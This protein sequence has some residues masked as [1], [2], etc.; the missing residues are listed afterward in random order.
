MCAVVILAVFVLSQE[1]VGATKRSVVGSIGSSAFSIG[2]ALLAAIATTTDNWR[3]LTLMV[4]VA[5]VPCA[6]LLLLLPESPRWLAS[7]GRLEEA[8]KVLQRIARLNGTAQALPQQW[9]LLP[10]GAEN[11]GSPKRDP[12]LLMDEDGEPGSAD[13]LGRHK[14]Q[15]KSKR[16]K[17]VLRKLD[18]KSAGLREMM[19]HGYIARLLLILLYSWFVNSAVYYGLTLAASDLGSNV[20]LST[21]LNGLVELPS[22][23]IVLLVIDRL[24]RRFT[25][26]SFMVFGG[27]ACLLVPLLPPLHPAYTGLALVGKLCISASFTVAYIHSGEIFPTCMRNTG[28]GLLSVSART[29][30]IVC[31]FILMLGD[32]APGLHFG[33]L[34]LLALTSGLL[35]ITLPETLGRPTPETVEDVLAFKAG[36][37]VSNGQSRY[38]RLGVDEET[39]GCSSEEDEEVV[40][41][42]RMTRAGGARDK[43]RLVD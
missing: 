31:N 1:V 27:T 25:L 13:W 36:P 2:I 35:N 6:G 40:E 26:V 3:T 4:S 12:L 5:G 8:T 32:I 11:S 19:R 30:G 17:K 28:I 18:E 43:G 20:Y 10:P 41:L 38:S 33:V 16:V 24:G 37:A 39:L 14:K 22:N 29:G 15:A 7:K 21:A 23:F 42:D 9:R 34:G